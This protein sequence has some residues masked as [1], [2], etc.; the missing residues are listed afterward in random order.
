MTTPIPM[1][2]YNVPILIKVLRVRDFVLQ[3]RHPHLV[4]RYT[5]L[6][7]LYIGPTFRRL[8]THIQDEEPSD[9]G[10]EP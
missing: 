2:K 9:G 6:E 1:A 5:R 4:E 8:P 3:V 10:I 7:L